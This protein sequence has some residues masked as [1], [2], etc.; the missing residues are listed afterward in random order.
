[1]KKTLIV[2]SL[3]L[4]IGL[5]CGVLG[6]WY[7]TDHLPQIKL[8]KEAIEHQAKLNQM[9]RSGEVLAVKKD[10]LTI[11]VENNA[12]EELNGKEITVKTN[13]DTSIQEGMDFLSEPGEPFDLTSKLKVGMTVDLMVEGDTALAVHWPKTQEETQEEAETTASQTEN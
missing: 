12:D 13:P 4:V 1:M 2:A 6:H 3:S 5:G 7:F 10:E 11:K 9:V 8:K